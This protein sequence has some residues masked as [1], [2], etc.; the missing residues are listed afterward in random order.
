MFE[1]KQATELA[2]A[3]GDKDIKLTSNVILKY[4]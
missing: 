3:K 1:L 2:C 4:R